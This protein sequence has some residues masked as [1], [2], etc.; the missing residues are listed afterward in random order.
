MLKITDELRATPEYQIALQAALD[1]YPQMNRD[2]FEM[3]LVA[4]IANPQG[5]LQVDSVDDKDQ[6]PV[7]D[8]VI[9]VDDA[10]TIS[11]DDGD[12]PST[13]LTQVSEGD[14]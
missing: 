3:A 6:P 9:G 1:T 13:D 12:V 14:A 7:S 8:P 11:Q 10:V 2:I 4:A 5:H